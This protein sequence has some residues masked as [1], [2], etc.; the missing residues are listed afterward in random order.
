MASQR[1][2]TK[3]S[4]KI[5]VFPEKLGGRVI[6][7]KFIDI[8][9]DTFPG[10]EA[11]GANQKQALKDFTTKK[12]VIL[13]GTSGTGKTELCS[14][15]ASRQFYLGEVDTIIITRPYKSL[16]N[17]IGYLPGNQTQKLLPMC[18]SMLTKL[19][20]YLGVNVLRNS[21]K[22]LD[23]EDLFTE[24]SGITLIPV[25]SMQGRS[26]GPKTLIIAD[27]VQNTTPA[28]AKS[29]VTRLEE[30]CQLL[31]TGDPIQ[32][33]LRGR[34][35]LQMLE[36]MLTKHPHKDASMIKFS[37]VDNCR[38]GISG[39]LAKMFEDVGTWEGN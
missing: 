13:S 23:E 5:E 1:G 22:M 18:M 36:E 17:E 12:M 6:K 35:G 30:G 3:R 31:V 32:S 4:N 28:Q 21:F 25:E 38:S 11:K 19:K 10:L 39:H 2:A 15:W 33:A 16:G 29:L 26:F 34:N 37:P 14:W 24:V 20:K 9:K 7:E 27:E 8:R